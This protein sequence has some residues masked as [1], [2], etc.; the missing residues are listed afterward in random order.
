MSKS[1]AK[2]IRIVYLLCP[3]HA[4]D[5]LNLVGSQLPTSL[6]KGIV[7]DKWPFRIMDV[8]AAAKLVFWGTGDS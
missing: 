7:C 6:R 1:Q 8:V 2:C 3:V 5:V 4:H